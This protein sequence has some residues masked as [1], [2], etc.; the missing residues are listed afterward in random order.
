M[1]MPFY[2]NGVNKYEQYQGLFQQFRK[3]SSR[4]IW[5]IGGSRLLFANFCHISVKI[6]NFFLIIGF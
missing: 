3:G 5:D 4:G 6:N 1:V 2:Q